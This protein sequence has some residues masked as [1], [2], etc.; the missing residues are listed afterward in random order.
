[1]A[2]GS[3]TLIEVLGYENELMNKI[4]LRLLLGGLLLGCTVGGLLLMQDGLTGVVY[5]DGTDRAIP[6]DEVGELFVE[7]TRIVIIDWEKVAEVLLG[8]SLIIGG[9]Y[10]ADRLQTRFGLPKQH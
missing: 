1:M 8:I 9:I 5:S 4:V 7:Q 10:A 2:G 6:G 3:T